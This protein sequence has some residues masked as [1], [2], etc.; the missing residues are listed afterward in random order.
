MDAPEVVMNILDDKIF[1]TEAVE[2]PATA[3]LPFRRDECSAANVFD[4]EVSRNANGGVA[5]W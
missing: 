4:L 3:H 1:I 5:C 2:K